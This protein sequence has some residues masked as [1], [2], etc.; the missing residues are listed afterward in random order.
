MTPEIQFDVIEQKI[1]NLKEIRDFSWDTESASKFLMHSVCEL[2]SQFFFLDAFRKKNHEGKWWVEICTC[3]NQEAKDFVENI[4]EV[5]SFRDMLQYIKYTDYLYIFE[6]PVSE[7][8]EEV[9]F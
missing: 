3:D 1:T 7:G 2:S 6:V 4:L 8:C 5:E 9:V